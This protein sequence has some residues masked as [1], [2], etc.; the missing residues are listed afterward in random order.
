MN[1]G[2][3]KYSHMCVPQNEK[4]NSNQDKCHSKATNIILY[5]TSN[6]NLTKEIKRDKTKHD[7]TDCD[8]LDNSTNFTFFLDLLAIVLRDGVFL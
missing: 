8:D 4:K 5:P 2:K 7:N 1:L 6:K 3:S